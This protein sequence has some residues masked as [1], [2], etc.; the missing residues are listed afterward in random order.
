MTLSGIP[1]SNYS[2]YAYLVDSTQGYDE[3]VTVGGKTYYY[4]PTNA[5]TY[6]QVTNTNSASYPAGNYV[7]ASGLTGS[8]QTLFVQGIGEPYGSFAGFEIVNST[9]NREGVLPASTPVSIAA[10]ATLDLGGGSQQVSSLSDSAAGSGG[11]IINSGSTAS[12]LTLSPSGVSTTFSG[13]IQGGGTMGSI[14][15]VMSGSG[16]QVLAGSNTYTGP[17]TINAGKLIVNG[18]L[19]SPVTVNHGAMLGGTGSLR[20]VTISLSSVIAPGSPLGTL[21]LSGSLILSSRAMLDYDLDTPATSSMIDCG[22]VCGQFARILQLQLREHVELPPRRLR[23]DPVQYLAPWQPAGHKHQRLGRWIPGEP[24]RLGQ[25]TGAHRRAGAGDAGAARGCPRSCRLR[26][27]ATESETREAFGLRP[28]RRLSHPCLP[29]AFVHG[30]CGTK[31]SLIEQPCRP[32]RG[33]RPRKAAT[34]KRKA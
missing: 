6:T 16:T 28:T 13:T 31:G 23:L 4:S 29:L 27:A 2:I 11:S 17:T 15:L 30:D 1:Y 19:V 5:A 21:T 7:V 26:L 9:P 14:G 12:T 18:S 24:V 32:G 10:G 8:S 25:R 3:E 20:S 33:R 34:A 22:Q